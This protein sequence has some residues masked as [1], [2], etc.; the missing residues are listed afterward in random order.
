M[1]KLVELLKQ[2]NIEKIVAKDLARNDMAEVIE[3]AFRYDRLIIASP[4]YDGGLFPDTEKFL[5]QLKSKNYQN[6]KIGIIEN[7]SWAAMVGKCV[8]DIVKDMKNIDICDPVVTIKTTMN[9]ET[10]EKM[11]MLINEIC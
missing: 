9:D 1:D 6:R 10:I 3:D 11:K 8:R 2:K 7:G 5:R 4:T